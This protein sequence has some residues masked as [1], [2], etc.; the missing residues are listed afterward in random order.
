MPLFRPASNITTSLAGLVTVAV[1][2]LLLFGIGVG[3]LLVDQKQQAIADRLSGTAGALQVAVDR[4]LL[5]QF[6]ALRLIADAGD[7][8][9]DDPRPFQENAKKYLAAHPTW[10]NLSLIDPESHQLVAASL[11]LPTPRPTTLAVEAVDQVRQSGEPVFAGA[12]PG[13][14]LDPKP[15]L[16]LLAPVT[17]NGSACLVLA[18]VMDVQPLSAVF[19]E[20]RLPPTWTGAVVDRQMIVVARSRDAERLVGS[21][22]AP[23]LAAHLAEAATGMFTSETLDGETV[24]TLFTRSANTGLNVVLGIPAAEAAG[25]VRL[26]LLRII[27]DGGCLMLVALALAAMVGRR[28]IKVRTSYEQ[29]ILER[30]H[31]LAALASEQQI[32]L[33]NAPFAIFKIVDRK[34][35]WVSRKA[36]DLLQY[37]R[38]DML[39]QTTR[40]YY[41][42]DEDYDSLGRS[43]YSA[44]TELGEYETVVKLR[45]RDGEARWF[46]YSGKAVDASD[47]SKGAIWVLEDLTDRRDSEARMAESNRLLADQARLL[48]AANAE[49]E[50]FAYIASHDLRQPLRM[51]VNYL[52]LIEKRLAGTLPPDLQTYFAFASGGARRMDNLIRDLLAYSQVGRTDTATEV[53]ALTIPLTQSL[54]NLSLSIA[55]SGAEIAVADDW[56]SVSGDASDVERLFQNLIGNA[57]KYRHPERPPVVEIGHRQDDDRLVVWVRDNGTGIAPEHRDRVFAIFQRLVPRDAVE[58]TGIGLAICKKIVERHGGRIWIEDAPE[59]GAV[60]LFSLP[61]AVSS[62][63]I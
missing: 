53:F 29:A 61:A 22:T 7:V 40:M 5:S 35:V 6:G 45:R 10:R 24:L 12:F 41:F 50:Q 42:T 15:M 11:P 55:E 49:L 58:G 32:I 54:E 3:W 33:N 13:G 23:S 36:E 62:F 8:T 39:G 9:C 34:Q 20:S 25:P 57:I 56:P 60:F 30:E 2:P 52:S 27:V 18:A 43:A 19:A 37:E 21:K 46:R 17:R 47:M 44:L 31:R 48:R 26:L 59:G 4:E 38:K 51:V 1:V 63:D 16:M 28:I 14:K